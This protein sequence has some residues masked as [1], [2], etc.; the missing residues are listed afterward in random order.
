MKTQ[1]DQK[2]IPK[3][4]NLIKKVYM[5]DSIYITLSKWQSYKEQIIICQALSFKES[6]TNYKGWSHK[7][8]F[9]G[10]EIILSPKYVSVYTK[11]HI[12]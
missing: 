5:Y 12:L 10:N 1:C 4:K 8:S 7:V 2:S 6:I 9:Y 11:L 3:E